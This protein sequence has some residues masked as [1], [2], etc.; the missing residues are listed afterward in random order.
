MFCHKGCIQEISS[1]NQKI[2]KFLCLKSDTFLVSF[3]I[4]VS[5]FRSS[6]EIEFRMFTERLAVDVMRFFFIQ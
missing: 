5:S 6:K 3:G 4:S 2:L 1:S